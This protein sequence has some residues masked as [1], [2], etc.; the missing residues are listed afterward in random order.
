[1]WTLGDGIDTSDILSSP[2]SLVEEEVTVVFQ[3][4][5]DLFRQRVFAQEALCRCTRAGFERPDELFALA[6]NEGSVGR[7]GKMVREAALP[8]DET[9]RVFINLHPRELESRWIVRPDDP[10]YLYPGPVFLEVTEAAALDH[11]ELCRSVLREVCSRIG[12]SV[13][14]DDFGA[15]YSNLMR[16]IDLQPAVVKLDRTLVHGLPDN[17]RQQILVRNL[18]RLCTDLS[19]DVVAE[20][21]ETVDELRAVIDC[22]VRFGQGYLLARPAMP[23]PDIVWPL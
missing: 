21:I 16:I 4:I 7:L 17:R 14:V 23:A 8:P 13:V 5:V 20:G 12:A 9:Q 3:P 15:G 22:G 2:R 6:V 10:L 1:M 18:A 19:A 11:Y